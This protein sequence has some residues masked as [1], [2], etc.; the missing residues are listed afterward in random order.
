V[1]IATPRSPERRGSHVALRHPE[2]WRLCRALIEEL[3][4]VPDFREP[5][6]L[7]FGITPINTRFVD[8]WDAIERLHV[9]LAER[10]YERFP[11]AR[12]RVT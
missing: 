1:E 5:D 12:A 9:A 3:G 7:R 6:L 4:V 2:A 10:R 8:V 11:L